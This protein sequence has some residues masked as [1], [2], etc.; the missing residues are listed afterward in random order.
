M[1]R[2]DPRL[3]WVWVRRA[4]EWERERSLHEWIDFAEHGGKWVITG[5]KERMEELA[6]TLDPYVESGKI[7]DIKYSKRPGVYGP[8][9]A[10]CV[11]C[12]EW[13]R[14]RVAK[15]LASVGVEAKRW[16]SEKETLMGFAPGGRHYIEIHGGERVET[17]INNCTV[18]IF[19]RDIVWM[20][21]DAIVNS[22]T[23]DLKMEVGLSGEIA[24]VGGPKIQEECKR[25]GSV[26]V[27]DAIITN[28][29]E[30][31]ARYVIH[32]VGPQMGEGEEDEKLRK[33]MQNC[34]ELAEKYGLKSVAFPAIS[35]GR[36]RIPLDR[37]ARIMLQTAVP[38]VKGNT[39]LERLVF[40][41]F[42]KDNFQVFHNELQALQG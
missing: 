28:G 2:D 30:L 40:C 8:L 36:F 14:E 6:K 7:P 21:V 22:T 26:S 3:P 23:P 33:T 29:G 24:R 42:G 32:A 34:L 4:S 31:K 17:E 16:R 5:T 41:V 18:E 1:I 25:V 13:D 20:E 27:G 15:I 35:T 37:S 39:G 38:Y 12:Y 9:P 19:E 10:M 11:F